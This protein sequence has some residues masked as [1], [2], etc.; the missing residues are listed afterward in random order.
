MR[1]T[2]AAENVTKEYGST[3]VLER[4]SL[5]VPPRARVGVVGANGSGKTTLLRLLTALAR[6]AGV[7]K[8]ER[9]MDALAAR[10][11]REP[12][13]ASAY[14]DA[15]ERFLSLGGRDFDAR[16]RSVCA[17]L[18]LRLPLDAELPTLSG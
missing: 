3:T 11:D 7:A 9:K 4:L 6:R 5:V 1:G 10:L 2:L 8:A 17:E 15:L 12:E 14:N 18:G 13:L 16:A